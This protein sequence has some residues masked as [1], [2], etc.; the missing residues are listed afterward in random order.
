MNGLHM[1][2]NEQN[3]LAFP[4]HTDAN[5][6]KYTH[7][8]TNIH[9]YTYTQH[10]YTYTHIHTHTHIYIHT[11]THT[12]ICNVHAHTFMHKHAYTCTV[13]DGMSDSLHH[14]LYKQPIDL[15]ILVNIRMHRNVCTYNAC[16][17]MY[18]DTTNMSRDT[19]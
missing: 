16:I 5:T 6:Q 8:P 9:I 12:Y 1:A 10:T 7:I 14:L 19:R 17:E 3:V 18:A 15:E 13:G 4:A 11:H 2:R